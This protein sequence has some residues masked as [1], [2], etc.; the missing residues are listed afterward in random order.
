[1]AVGLDAQMADQSD[2]RAPKSLK[3]EGGVCLCTGGSTCYCT[4]RQ[5]SRRK[6][7]KMLNS[8]IMQNR[9]KEA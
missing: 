6:C 7:S 3:A 8:D 9:H 5:Y 4:G 2:A 1:M